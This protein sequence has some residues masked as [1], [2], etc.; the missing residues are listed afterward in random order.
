MAFGLLAVLIAFSVA[1]YAWV[2]NP[3]DPLDDEC[4]STDAWRQASDRSLRGHMA[5]D[6]VR[7]VIKAGLTEPQILALLGRP[8][9]VGDQRG[10]R[11]RSLTGTRTYIYG[12]GNWT[13]LS[14]DD[15]FVYVYLDVNQR[16]VQAEIHGY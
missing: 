12:I 11:G 4:F 1:M 10:P 6:L 15:A 2:G 9:Y 14:M 3:F 5:R 16:V 13:W 8:D 7:H